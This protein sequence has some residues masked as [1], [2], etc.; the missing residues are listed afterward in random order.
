MLFTLSGKALKGGR[1]A[2]QVATKFGWIFKE[3]VPGH[4][5]ISGA[6]DF[7]RQ[8]VEILS[9]GLAQRISTCK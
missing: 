5:G 4:I 6:P 3:L 1:E 8:Q 7:V 9:G 2:Y